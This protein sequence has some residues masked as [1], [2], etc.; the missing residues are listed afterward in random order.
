MTTANKTYELNKINARI[1]EITAEP[2][3][4]IGSDGGTHGKPDCHN[5]YEEIS[6]ERYATYSFANSNASRCTI[7]Q[8][9]AD[10]NGRIRMFTGEINRMASLRRELAQLKRELAEVKNS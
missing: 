10:T 3:A 7:E 8:A 4:L 2:R 9:E 6:G 5:L 1:K